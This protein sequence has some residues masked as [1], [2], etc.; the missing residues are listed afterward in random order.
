M[1]TKKFLFWFPKS[2]TEKPIVYH[3]VKDY[4]LIINIFRAKVTPEEEGYLV[5]D[6]TG[7]E[8]DIQRGLD[9]VKTF[10]VSINE[11][12]RGLRWDPDRCTHCGNC[13]PHCPTEAL[14]IPDRS[15]MR[16]VFKE[17]LC[18]ECL[19]CVENCVYGACTSMF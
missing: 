16:V 13:I 2:E 1:I 7:K 4:N 12:G 8:K 18:I 11:G 14:Y 15:S 10:N 9:Y 6:V 3:L 5:L 17:E 19:S